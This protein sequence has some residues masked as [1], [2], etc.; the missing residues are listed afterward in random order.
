M[1]ILNFS[2]L[3]LIAT[4]IGTWNRFAASNQF[5]TIY[6]QLRR[7]VIADLSA[8]AAFSLERLPDHLEKGKYP[9]NKNPVSLPEQAIHKLNT[10]LPHPEYVAYANVRIQISQDNSTYE[11]TWND[12]AWFPDYIDS[13][14][15][16]DFNAF[17]V[18][19]GSF[20]ISWGDGKQDTI[21][22]FNQSCSHVY[23]TAGH[24]RI[25]VY[26]N[27]AFF[28]DPAVTSA[29]NMYRLKNLNFAN[30][31]NLYDTP[32]LTG[33]SLLQVLDLRGTGITVS[34]VTSGLKSLQYL[35]LN[36]TAI[37]RPPDLT[38]NLNLKF[39]SFHG[40]NF[41]TVQPLV[42]KLTL[43]EH[44]D[45]YGTGLTRKDLNDILYALCL[46][47]HP[48]ITMV[49]LRV[50]H[51]VIPDASYIAAFHAAYPSA[52]LLIN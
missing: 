50:S 47:K 29:V 5:S 26:S 13:Q 22:F 31:S 48:Q 24:Y 52:T 18:S 30:C 34:P 28:N 14:W 4:V 46:N 11:C 33:L 23:A 2:L 21:N 42:S 41:L 38:A 51:A 20:L 36:E 3:V 12:S 37:S 15:N 44:L 17:L 27:Y 6:E 8:T 25:T 9:F 40:C 16:F 35:Y 10:I 19:L 49:N 45:L 43:L 7:N 39:L 1:K 32:V